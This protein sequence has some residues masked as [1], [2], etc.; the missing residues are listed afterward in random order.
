MGGSPLV[1]CSWAPCPAWQSA[2][3]FADAGLRSLSSSHRCLMSTF[4]DRYRR[5]E[6]STTSSQHR[7]V[8]GHFP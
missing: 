8:P 4:R 1:C 2:P 5:S 7:H 3:V 6:I